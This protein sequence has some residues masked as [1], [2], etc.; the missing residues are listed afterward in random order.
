VE[1]GSP[2]TSN[3]SPGCEDA[4]CCVLV[5]DEDPYCCE[6]DWDLTCA[7]S[8]VFRCFGW[9]EGDFNF[10]GLVDGAD[11]GLLMS[12]WG[13]R[14]ALLEDLNDDTVVDGADLGFFLGKWGVCNY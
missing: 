6:T 1:A 8:A 14:S 13:S 12:A 9:C 7:R 5:C 3:G 2:F 4:G 11:L 10:D